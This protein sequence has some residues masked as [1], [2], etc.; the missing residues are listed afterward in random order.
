MDNLLPTV[1]F[2]M[3]SRKL[4]EDIIDLLPHYDYLDML[5]TCRYLP[6]KA[7]SMSASLP[8]Y[9][10]FC[11]QYG[12]DDASLAELA[13]KGTKELMT[14]ALYILSEFADELRGG[15]GARDIYNASDFTSG[16]VCVCTNRSKMYGA[17]LLYDK[18][19][20]CHLAA[21]FQESYHV[22]PSGIHEFLAVPL[23]CGQNVKYLESTLHTLNAD[24]MSS[25]N[26]LSENVLYYNA[27]NNT[28]TVCR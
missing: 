18:D 17:S 7:E 4:N 14:P 12:L 10:D 5:V 19:V 24:E 9:Y 1:F 15:A 13:R 26:I 28:L 16:T 3:R 20:L 11:R 23:S 21:L 22:V 8:V 2:H 25:V 27:E 6:E